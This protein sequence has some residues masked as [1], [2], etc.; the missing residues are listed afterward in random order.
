[1]P[2][3]PNMRRL[4]LSYSMPN[5]MINSTRTS[6]RTWRITDAEILMRQKNYRD[7][8]KPLEKFLTMTK[9]KK[10]R[11]RPIFILAQ[12]YEQ[13]GD[14]A[15]AATYYMEVLKNN[16]GMTWSFMPSCAV[17]IWAASPGGIIRWR[18]RSS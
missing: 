10:E 5:Q 17:P 9:K 16:P 2:L 18:S 12:I 3:N 14:Y 1:M 4:L 7:A 13:Q 11:V 6:T 8:I 15:H